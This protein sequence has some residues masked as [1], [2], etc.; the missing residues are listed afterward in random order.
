MGQVNTADLS[1]HQVVS[2]VATAAA[3]NL[4]LAVTVDSIDVTGPAGADVG[5]VAAA[6]GQTFRLIVAPS[7]LVVSVSAPDTTNLLLRQ[8]AVGLREFL[9]RIPAAPV[10]AGQSWTD[11]V[12]TVN[13]GEVS[14]TSHAVRQNRVVGWEDRDGVR[15]LHIASAS[16]YTVTGSGEAQGQAIELTGSGQSTRDAFISAAGVFLGS[17]EADSASLSAN[18]T[19][20]GL[21]VPIHQ[22]RRSTVTRVP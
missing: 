17:I 7:G 8:V 12:T 4:A 22:T 15:A 16:T 2:V 10:T 6:R 21:T 11:S 14:V 3:E 13:S 18:V 19:S 9:P 20:V 1:S 5:A